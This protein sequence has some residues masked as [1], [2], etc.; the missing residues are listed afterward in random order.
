M[1]RV[2]WSDPRLV[3]LLVAA[4]IAAA[5]LH[6]VK[7]PI[8]PERAV[9]Q[10]YDFVQ[11]LPA[12]SAMLLAVDFDPQAKAELV[13]ITKALLRHCLRRNLR[14]IGMTFWPQGAALG[15]S[16][17]SVVAH[18]PESADKKLGTDYVYL[19]YKPG[20]MAQVITNMGENLGQTF[21]QDY[22]N[23][24]TATMPIFQDVASLKDVDYL[25]DL[26]AGGTPDAW[27][28]F[29]ADKYKIPMAVGCTAVIGPD[30]YVRL[31][32]GQINGLIAGLRGAADY[33]VLLNRP[34][35]GVGGMFAQSIIHVMIIVLVAAGNLAFFWIARRRGG[36][37]PAHE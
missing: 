23:R 21:R 29:G 16:I 17:F 8:K 11:R 32:A 12:G 3:F 20:D 2:R 34:D 25:V 35:L 22:E 13:P 19:G 5:L 10:V 1:M 33:E 18:E 27:V 24:P 6:P 36:S 9:V 37:T 31:N 30:M 7:Q 14:V 4:A 26:A 15:Q 28:L